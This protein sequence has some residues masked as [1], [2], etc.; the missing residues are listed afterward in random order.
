MNQEE[1]VRFISMRIVKTLEEFRQEGFEPAVLE[2]ALID[3]IVRFEKACFS[4]KATTANVLRK[5]SAVVLEMA[6]AEEAQTEKD[7]N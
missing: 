3:A 1:Q 4:P 7:P 6:R 5:L 2:V